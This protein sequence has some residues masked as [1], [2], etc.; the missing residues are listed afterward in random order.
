MPGCICEA[1]H[2]KLALLKSDAPAFC[3]C[4]VFNL[5]SGRFSLKVSRRT[6]FAGIMMWSQTGHLRSQCGPIHFSS[7]I[8]ADMKSGCARLA[9][10]ALQMWVWTAFTQCFRTERSLQR[11][12][13]RYFVLKRC[14]PRFCFWW[15]I[16]AAICRYRSS[17]KG[18]WVYAL[19]TNRILGGQVN[20]CTPSMLACI[21]I[22]T[23]IKLTTI[24]SCHGVH[25]VDMQC[26][27]C[28]WCELETGPMNQQI[29]W[30][31]SIH[32]HS[33][34]DAALWISVYIMYANYTPAYVDHHLTV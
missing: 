29:I 11:L 3:L 24:S 5:W 15:K 4:T 20:L 17:M 30:M 1:L 34:A 21:Q 9:Q 18:S 14:S 13:A 2:E 33:N 12:L 7:W 32:Q 19:A 28:S 25:V 23:I 26:K 16:S 27:L 8:Q 22:K 10:H 6:I 31:K